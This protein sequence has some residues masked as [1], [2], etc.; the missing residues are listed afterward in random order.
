MTRQRHVLVV[1]DVIRDI[2]VIPEGPIRRGSDV[3]AS[4]QIVPGG[5][6]AN[7]AKWLAHQGV[8]VTLAARVGAADLN[9]LEKEFSRAG[10]NPALTGDRAFETGTLINISEPGG[11]RSFLTDRG[12]NRNLSID[13]ISDEV[14]AATDLLLLSGYLFFAESGRQTAL[15]LIA[16]AQRVN[17]RTAVDAASAGYI[18]DVGVSAFLKWT[19][20]VDVLF[21]NEEEAQLL[22]GKAALDEQLT[23]LLDHFPQVV[24]K[25][26]ADGATSARRGGASDHASAVVAECVD[27]TGAGDAFAAGFLAAFLRGEDELACLTSG[28][29]AA[30]IAVGQLG[31]APRP[32]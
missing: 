17:V 28:N 6:G 23:V 10:V 7:Q 3:N 11:E 18:A 22:S 20:G 2:L 30:S 15:D 13:D 26:G 14:L 29:L 4:I 27:S 32:G 24:I 25:Q 16:W 12:A 9:T 31:G 8:E 19:S 1:G 21:A 5:S